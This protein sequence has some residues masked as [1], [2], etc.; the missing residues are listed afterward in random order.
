MLTCIVTSTTLAAEFRG[1][2]IGGSCE[3]VPRHE[4]A[5][6]SEQ[7]ESVRADALVFKGRLLDRPILIGYG[8]KNDLLS[9]G[10]LAFS[11]DAYAPVR[12][13]FLALYSE[14][15]SSYGQPFM[16]ASPPE[17]A[18]GSTGYM[19]QWQIPNAGITLIMA[20]ERGEPDRW[21]VALGYTL[22]LGRK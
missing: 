16:D 12:T 6:G 7:M 21:N 18:G 10:S 15:V 8:C 3:D 2:E 22:F 4:K 1:S 20:P 19:A 17:N 9:Q 13:I 14:L 5:L 11:K